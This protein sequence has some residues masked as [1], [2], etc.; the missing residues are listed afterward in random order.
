MCCEAK[1]N[2]LSKRVST[3]EEDLEITEWK[4]RSA[5]SKPD[6]AGTA[7]DDAERAK[8]VH[9]NKAEDDDKRLTT[10]EKEL[11]EARETAQTAG[12]AYDEVNK[13][14]GA[15]EADLKKAEE[16]ADVGETKIL[17]LEEELR[18]AANN[19][20]SLEVAEEKANHREKTYKE[21][22]KTLTS[23]SKWRRGLNLLKNQFR[24]SKKK[25]T[26]YKMNLWMN[27]RNLRLLLKNLN[28]PLLKC[29]VIICFFLFIHKLWKPQGH[30]EHCIIIV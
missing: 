6:K 10:L 28:K 9:Q 29:L 26:T 4:F 12:I 27:R 7:G 21:Q 18:V 23:W 1:M 22:I 5:I 8:K 24:N 3:L 16:R 2:A 15:C 14:L 20:K 30:T 17:E 19:L 11:K 25:L 13:R